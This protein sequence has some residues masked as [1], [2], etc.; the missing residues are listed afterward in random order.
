MSSY[1]KQCLYMNLG[2]LQC[3]TQD[4][5]VGWRLVVVG[6]VGVFVMVVNEG[7]NGSLDIR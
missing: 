6:G 3:S 2:P 7:F 4:L 1:Y 5:G